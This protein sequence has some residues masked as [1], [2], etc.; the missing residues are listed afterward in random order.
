MK[1]LGFIGCGHIAKSLIIG[2]KRDSDY[3]IIGYDKMQ[4]SL[5]WLKINNCTPLSLDDCC[6]NADIL[7]LCVK[8]QDMPTLCKELSATVNKNQS[9]V[10]VA[11]GIKYESLKNSLPTDKIFRAMPNV[12]AKDNL[13]ITAIFSHSDNSEILRIF[14]FLGEAY[15]VENED[16]IDLHTVLIGSGPA[17]FYELL[18]EFER[19]MDILVQDKDIKRLISIIFLSSLITSIKNGENLD[20]LIESVASKGGTTEAGLNFLYK[21]KFNEIFSGAV[22]A[23]VKRAKELSMD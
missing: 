7:F 8:P 4:Y 17:F 6:N 10:S 21:E 23:G 20:D 2:L 13:G 16:Q 18:S 11:A 1:T 12:G 9:I 5:D 19:R 14:K 15:E 3:E 22:D